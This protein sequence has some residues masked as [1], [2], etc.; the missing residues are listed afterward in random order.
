M[1][2][3]LIERIVGNLA[4]MGYRGR[5]SWFRVN[6][7]LLDTR[8]ERILGLTRKSL[9]DCWLTLVTNG[10]LLTWTR[11]RSLKAA[12]LDALGISIYDDVAWDRVYREGFHR[13][14]VVFDRRPAQTHRFVDNR[15]GNISRPSEKGSALRQKCFRPATMMSVMV[16]GRVALCNPDLY[17]EIDLGDLNHQRIEEV[18]E[19]ASM[20]RYRYQLMALGREGLPLCERCDYHG[21]GHQRHYPS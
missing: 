4:E 18:W 21:W 20:K 7:P 15:A 19:N 14:C 5:V 16:N 3:P 9:P 12:G 11:Y 2:W 10:D 6:E 13:D 17:G 1:A 8:L